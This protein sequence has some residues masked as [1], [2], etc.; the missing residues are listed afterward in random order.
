MKTKKVPVNSLRCMDGVFALADQPEG[1]EPSDKFVP[2]KMVARSGDPIEHWLFGQTVHDNEGMKS[3]ARIAVDWMHFDDELVG[4]ANTFEVVDGNLVLG[5]AVTSTSA[6][7]RAGQLIAQARAGIPF[8][9]SIQFTPR[10]PGDTKIEELDAGESAEVNGRTINGPATIFREWPLVRV[11]ICP[12]GADANTSTV[13][14]KNEAEDVELTIINKETETMKNEDK[15]TDAELAADAAKV[16]AESGQAAGTDAG[17][18]GSEG[19]ADGNGA[20]NGVV[21]DQPANVEAKP[22]DG[23]SEFKLFADKFGD[24]RAASYFKEGLSMETAT[25]KYTQSLEAENVALKEKNAELSAAVDQGADFEPADSKGEMVLS[26]DEEAHAKEYARANKM[27]V[28]KGRAA[29]LALKK[30]KQEQSKD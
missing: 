28:E 22:S 8:E 4:Y 16:D 26:A 25:E 27:S 1:K 29:V 15:K 7:D 9:A 17:G 20:D 19:E 23:R 11:A 5:G 12:S 30:R 13:M 21:T 18:A 14:N 3:K 2:F 6:G 24:E 10:M